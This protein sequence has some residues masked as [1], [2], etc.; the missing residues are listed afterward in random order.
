MKT[1]RLH[2]ATLCCTGPIGAHSE[3]IPSDDLTQIIAE[4]EVALRPCDQPLAGSEAK[5]LAACYPTFRASKEWLGEVE[6]A[7]KDAPCDLIKRAVEQ[8]SEEATFPPNKAQV[9]T[10]V[11][12]LI[13]VRKAILARAQN[14]Q[15]EHQRRF[16][17]V[18]EE[19]TRAEERA[20]FRK[21]LGGKSP[22]EYFQQ[23]ARENE[24]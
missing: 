20:A 19:K 23:K 21:K 9:K 17:E 12:E 6:R 3:L 8:L 7:L 11:A 4:M 14:M 10:K 13:R 5:R 16:L 22:L 24:N 18:A 1:T 15:A 2:I